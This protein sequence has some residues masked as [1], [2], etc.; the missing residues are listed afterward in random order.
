MSGFCA[1]LEPKIGQ[2]C[3]DSR[4]AFPPIIRGP[5]RS[6]RQKTRNERNRD[7][8]HGI[9]AHLHTWMIRAGPNALRPKFCRNSAIRSPHHL[10]WY[11]KLGSDADWNIQTHTVLIPFGSIDPT[12]TE[13]RLVRLCP[14]YFTMNQ[15]PHCRV[16]RL[17]ATPRS[18]FIGQN[19]GT[20]RFDTV[21]PGIWV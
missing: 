21:P 1:G 16:S 6:R 8:R 2:K 12:Y 18:L 14:S 20:E 7:G 19:S 9:A 13:N 11:K 5:V 15:K 10:P 17:S 4:Q 3:Q